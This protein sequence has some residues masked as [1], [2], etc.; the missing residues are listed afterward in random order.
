VA[1]GRK[2]NEGEPAGGPRAP[3]PLRKCARPSGALAQKLARRLRR[4]QWRQWPSAPAAGAIG[5]GSELAGRPTAAEWSAPLGAAQ[6]GSARLNSAQ[7][8]PAQLSSAQLG[9]A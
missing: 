1:G 2:T 4:L 8:G 7:L 6:L 5:G 9:S 3:P